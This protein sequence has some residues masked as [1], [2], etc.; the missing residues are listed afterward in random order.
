MI[1]YS[2][3]NND[4]NIR[5]FRTLTNLI[6]E[7]NSLN[8]NRSGNTFNINYYENSSS[9]LDSD[10]R[11]VQINTTDTQTNTNET[12]RN[13]NE[14]T[15]NTNTSNSNNIAV[16][17]ISIPIVRNHQTSLPDINNINSF[18]MDSINETMETLSNLDNNS[19]NLKIDDLL[20]KTTLNLR[21]EIDNDDEKCHICNENY[22]PNSICRKINGCQHFFHSCCI[23]KWFSTNNKCPI[24]NQTV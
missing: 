7:M 16:R 22:I 10:N 21:S 20:D 17:G 8:N 1:D 3:M 18:I 15:R 23:D 4:Y 14:T 24:C 5:D 2:I 13:N 19:E 6:H 12:T 9:N 11:P